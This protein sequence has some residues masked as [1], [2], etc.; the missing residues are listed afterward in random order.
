MK[1]N[2]W[3]RSINRTSRQTPEDR[4]AASRWQAPVALL[5][6][7]AVASGAWAQSVAELENDAAT[8][9]DIL[10]YGMGYAQQRFSPLEQINV[11]T[12]SQLVPVWSYSL[13]D[14][15]GQESFPLIRNGVMYTTTHESTVA[16]DALTGKQIWK[17]MLEY[18]AETPRV[19]CCGI[20][21]RGLAMLEGKLFRTTLDAHVMALDAQTGEQLWKSKAIDFRDGYSMTVAPLIADGVLI[22]GIS[23]GEYGIRGFI[24]GWDPD[25]GE[26]LWRRY[27]VPEPGQPGS[28][29][30]KDGGDA[31]KNGGGPAW[32]TGTYDPE[33]KTVYWGVGN[34]ASW[35][36]GIRP[37][38]NL[39]TGS[40]LALDPKTGDIKWHYQTSPNDPFDHDGTN[41][42]VLADMQIDGIERKVLMQAS[43][44]G[45]FYVLDRTNGD[46]LAANQYVKHLNWAEGI[47]L[48][49]GRPIDTDVVIKARAGEKVNF[50]PSAFGGKN[51]SPMSFHPGNQTVFANT[52]NMGMD[53]KAVEPQYRAGVFY[54]GA[55]FGFT[56][57]DDERGFLK[58]INPM[59]GESLWEVGTE[60]PR[61][62]GVLSTGGNL[63][64]T[65]KQTGEFEAFDAATGEKLWEFQTGSGIVGQPV[66]WELDG[67][68][69]ITILNGGGAVYALFAGDERLANVPAG[70]AVWT[71]ALFGS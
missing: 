53:Y 20:V 22:T 66:A 59:T 37:G 69:Y 71:F 51:W 33:L 63:V 70:G 15:R 30:W 52:L 45:F 36:A 43:R 39:Y 46:L 34:A 21:N 31:W 64:F 2:R 62:A 28:E 32:L 58:A 48:E 38:D 40:I 12:V 42:P 17:S 55:E 54:F 11:D 25:T 19:A 56:Y 1:F 24:D 29:T 35:N 41:E 61:L 6:S 27:T 67:R 5:L 44:N 16:L 26:Q 68:Q 47:D 8:P 57:P 49:T 13:D 23:G 10:T 18:P 65:G 4:T 60:I 50:T 7:G 14:D 3:L 9:E